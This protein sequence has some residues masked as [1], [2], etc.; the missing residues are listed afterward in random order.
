[1]TTSGRNSKEII[2]H[3]IPHLDRRDL[4]NLMLVSSSCYNMAA[5]LAYRFLR[6]EDLDELERLRE[7]LLN[8]SWARE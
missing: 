6:I 4:L 3:V 2:S 5:P 8:S 7:M 1:M